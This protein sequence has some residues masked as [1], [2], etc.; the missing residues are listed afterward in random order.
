MRGLFAGIKGGAY[1]TSAKNIMQAKR[2][3]DEQPG[4]R[5]ATGMWAYPE[6]TKEDFVA[7]FRSCLDIK[8][9]GRAYDETDYDMQSDRRIIEQYLRGHKRSGSGILRSKY[10]RKR[11]PHINNQKD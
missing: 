3:F 9:G 6:W 8:T 5:I 10:M 4:D 7:W 1:V 11:Y 2:F